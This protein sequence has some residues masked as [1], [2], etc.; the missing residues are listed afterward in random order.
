MQPQFA[1]EVSALRIPQFCYEDIPNFW[2]EEYQLLEVENLSDGFS[3]SGQDA[4]ISF[5]LATGEIYR[6][7]LQEKGEAIPKYMRASKAE[8]EYLRN[9]L[10]KLP[11][12]KKV[13][14]CVA[15]ICER[16][17]KNNRYA[18]QVISAYVHRVVENMTEDELAAMETA[19]PVYAQK[20]QDKK[21]YQ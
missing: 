2:G 20:I 15:Q 9:Q 3:L 12:E 14:R 17:N 7:D 5:E 6:V 11:P 21:L 4:Q 10:A 8:S 13:Q 1:E 19:I 16:L 18:T